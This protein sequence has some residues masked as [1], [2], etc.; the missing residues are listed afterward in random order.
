MNSSPSPPPKRFNAAVGVRSARFISGKPPFIRRGRSTG[1]YAVG[2]RYEREVHELLELYALG[3]AEFELK[4]G[5]WIEFF[6]RSGKRWCQP[7]ALV[8]NAPAREC[9][10]CEIKYQHTADAWWQL[11]Q[12]YQPVVAVIYPTHRLR[13]VEIVHWYDPLV[14]WPEQHHLISSIDAASYDSLVS[15]HIC[16]PKRG[17]RLRADGPRRGEDR[18]AGTSG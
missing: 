10:I 5:P 9:T 13:L 4:L 17:T 7:D 12:L 11:R 15:V 16:N 18:G 14:V 8:V 3:R 2:I 1:R 6:D